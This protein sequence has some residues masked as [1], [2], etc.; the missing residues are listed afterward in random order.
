MDAVAIVRGAV[1]TARPAA[2]A[3]RIDLQVD[4]APGAL[5]AADAN[6]VQQVLWNLLSNAIKFTPAGGCI[7]VEGLL[8]KDRFL[9]R[10]AD[11]GEG[12]DAA[13]LPYLFDR[14]RQADASMTRRHAGLGLGLSIVK[15]LVE[16]HGGDIQAQS[17]GPGKGA[18]FTVRL[19]RH[20]V[21]EEKKLPQAKPAVA[22]GSE[23]AGLQILVVDDD[24]DARNLV[25]RILEDCRASVTTAGSAAEAER[26]VRHSRFDVLV[27]DIGMPE[28]DGHMLMR[29]LRSL[30]PEHGGD[31]PAIALSA[32]AR[33][34]DRV[35]AVRAGFQ[36]HLAKPVEPAELIAVVASVG[37]RL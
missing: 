34:E 19:P 12:I 27:S 32:Y 35:Q 22:T 25:K 11:T 33:A 24:L 30:G 28:E 13:F 18:T 10:V 17:E 36:M 4:L 37:K 1:E 2:A 7:R 14:F 26:L 5:L 21:Q 23:I 8:Q 31:I 9:V 15:Q 16:L 20:P 3:K 6:R 29:K